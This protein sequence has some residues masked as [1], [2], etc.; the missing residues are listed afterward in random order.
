M[1]IV[2]EPSDYYLRNAGDAA[3]L[4]VALSRLS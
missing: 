4:G 2:V 3:M 1:R